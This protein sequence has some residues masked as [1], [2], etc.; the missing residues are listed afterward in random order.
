MDYSLLLG[1][2]RRRAGETSAS[3]LNSDKVGCWVHVCGEGGEGVCVRGGGDVLFWDFFFWG[4][5][6]GGARGLGLVHP[7]ALLF[8]C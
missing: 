6:G 7:S 4:G 1:L 2:H 5:G 8:P 3:P